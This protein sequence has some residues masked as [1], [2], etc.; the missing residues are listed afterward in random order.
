[1]R[2]CNGWCV[3]WALGLLAG[4]SP[5]VTPEGWGTGAS[6]GYVAGDLWTPAR[7]ADEKVNFAS[8]DAVPKGRWVEV[9][10]TRIDSLDSAVRSAVKGWSTADLFWG[11]V[12]NSR[13]YPAIDGNASRF[14]IGPSGGHA[15]GANNGLY[16]FDL[17]KMKW[18]IQSPP[19]DISTW[20]AEYRNSPMLGTSYTDCAEALE[21]RKQKVLDGTWKDIN[22]IS[23]DELLWDYPDHPKPTA[24]RVYHSLVFVQ[25]ENTL[26]LSARRLWKYDL[27]ADKWSYRRDLRTT[28]GD[29]PATDFA[30][31]SVYDELRKQLLTRGGDG[32]QV[33]HVFYDV[34]QNTFGNTFNAIWEP[35]APA[36]ER[37]AR[38]QVVVRFPQSGG[39]LGDYQVYDLDRTGNTAAGTFQL[40]PSLSQEEFSPA[41]YTYDHGGLVYVPPLD[42][43]W[44]WARF[45]DGVV[46]P[47]EIDPTT[48]PWT[49]NR[50]AHTGS[51]V[52]LNV[53]S[54]DGHPTAKPMWFPKLNAVVFMNTHEDRIAVYRF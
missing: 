47:I 14:W 15:D 19:S 27:A 31:V 29:T 6:V 3:A 43:Y 20:S 18:A 32:T 8:W 13:S 25:P 42:R 41:S 11:A 4:C 7:D 26:Y 50:L 38:S 12:T 5:A 52:A 30:F 16:R 46:H 49:L 22:D 53:T 48:T 54:P 40:G 51:L 9:D 36:T 34:A 24:R 45:S 39:D 35:H 1:M 2:Q 21:V 37:H 23:G 44:G 33:R 28:D 10:G 17:Y